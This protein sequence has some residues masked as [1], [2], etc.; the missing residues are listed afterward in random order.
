MSIAQ[1]QIRKIVSN[2][3]KEALQRGVLP[4]INYV[5]EKVSGRM[6][7]YPPGLPSM[8]LRPIEYREKSSSDEW[9]LTID[10]LHEDLD[11]LYEEMV[12]E[13]ERILVNFSYIE[14]EKRKVERKLRK[15]ESNIDEF[16]LINNNPYGYIHSFTE[17]FSDLSNTDH[18]ETNSYVDLRAGEVTPMPTKSGTIKL[19]LSDAHI[20]EKLITSDGVLLS[21]GLNPIENAVDDSENTSWIHKIVSDKPRD[22]SYRVRITPTSTKDTSRITIL[23]HITDSMTITVRVTEDG[24]NWQTVRQG[25]AEKLIIIDFPSLKLKDLDI[26]MSK[27]KYDDEEEVGSKIG[28]LYYFGLTNI[29]ILTLGFENSSVYQSKPIQ[30][31]D[32]Q[33]N[34]AI[35]NKLALEVDDEQSPPDTWVDYYISMPEHTSWQRITPVHY[36]EPVDKLVGSNEPPR[37]IDFKALKG[38]VTSESSGGTTPY[39]TFNGLDIWPL[40]PSPPSGHNILHRSGELYRGYRQWRH[41]SYNFVWSQEHNKTPTGRD[42]VTPPSDITQTSISTNYIDMTE[43]NTILES[44]APQSN[45]RWTTCIRCDEQIDISTNI[46]LSKSGYLT[47][48]INNMELVDTKGEELSAG[49][50]KSIN[51]TLQE[52]WNVIQILHYNKSTNEGNCNIDIGFSPFK[53]GSKVLTSVSP[54][55]EVPEFDLCYNIRE[56]ETGYFAIGNNNQILINNT[57]LQEN[58]KYIFKYK[59]YPDGASTNNEVI[60]KADMGKTPEST[61]PPKLKSYSIRIIS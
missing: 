5:R 43:H 16:L 19:D 51:F 15:L 10:E 20:Q 39:G 42:W 50:P 13:A 48:Y 21:E 27:Y 40:S 61:H 46:S 14:V 17:D 58:A 32:R 31:K 38:R 35:I 47:I 28:K 49:D 23:P 25:P 34:P 36:G 55:E 37:V 52:G 56:G 54:L 57:M 24:H 12:D 18:S 2:V 45:N 8:K 60:V 9:N 33:G 22:I 53:I 6:Q 26:T 4:T 29:S 7:E 11:V 1:I 30:I 59:Y 41:D 3:I 44:N